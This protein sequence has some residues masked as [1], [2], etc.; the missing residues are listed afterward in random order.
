MSDKIDG[1]TND[2][3]TA[4]EELVSH[5]A[6]T[7]EELSTS[8]A[9]QW[10]ELDKARRKLDALTARFLDLEEATA[11]SPEITKPPHY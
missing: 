8:V 9:T 7:I 5:Q 2:R 4:L 10:E 1:Q 3:L 6:K 11:P